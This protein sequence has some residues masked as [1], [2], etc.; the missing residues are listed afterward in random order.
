MLRWL[1]VVLH[2]MQEVVETKE[3]FITNYLVL[4]IFVGFVL[5]RSKGLLFD[6][7]EDSPCIYIYIF[8]PLRWIVI[9]QES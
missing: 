3:L 1:M 5:C 8:I 7:S 9:L 4:T 2:F 6:L